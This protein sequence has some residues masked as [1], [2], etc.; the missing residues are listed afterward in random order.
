VDNGGDTV[1][2]GWISTTTGGEH[3]H[4]GD[5]AAAT[6]ASMPNLTAR[7]PQQWTV[8]VGD[9]LLS[10]KFQNP[11]SLLSLTRSMERGMVTNLGN[12]L[13][14]WKRMLDLLHVA[15]PFHTETARA[16]GWKAPP[17]ASG[18]QAVKIYKKANQMSDEASNPPVS[19][20]KQ[21]LSP[22]SLSSE[23][24]IP[25]SACAVLLTV[26]PWCPRALLD[27]MV[28]VWLNDFGFSRVGFCCGTGAAANAL[29]THPPPKEKS[30]DNFFL[31][32]SCVVDLGWSATHVVPSLPYPTSRS[33]VQ[34]TIVRSAVRRVPLGGR[35]L[36]N[37][38]RYQ[39]SYRQWNLMDQEFV[40]RDV[41]EKACEVS[42]RF[43]EWMKLAS[44]VPA[45][46]RPY[47]REYLLPDFIRTFRGEMRLPQALAAA[48]EMESE[49]GRG[50]RNKD[51]EDED[52]EDS[53]ID[54]AEMNQ[55]ENGAD[56]NAKLMSDGDDDSGDD[57][58][59]SPEQIRRRLLQQREEENRRRR[60]EEAE[61]QVL[62]LSLERFA[63]PEVLFRPSDAGLPAEWA[64]LPA[65]IVQSICACPRPFQPALYRSIY[66]TG[67][68]SRMPGLRE[69][70]EREL[71]ALAPCE[72]N[73]SV[74][75]CPDPTS[76]AWRGACL[77]ARQRPV[78]TW[79]VSREDITDASFSS[80][81][82]GKHG[83]WKRMGED[84]GSLLV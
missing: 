16:F 67:G 13:Q 61:Q 66:L 50:E 25:A 8:L 49:Q 42:P 20:R 48:R 77:H 41:L 71:R 4:G 62:N 37:L 55:N 18:L 60:E 11:N 65:A 14:V 12:Q 34:Q 69:R 74:T 30:S 82:S 10:K 70:L 6:P 7:L 26:H 5:E 2:Y 29:A 3:D 43:D 80:K 38:W 35:H 59:E 58:N 46:R 15:I 79:S 40:L 17:P 28:S 81:S 19:G 33:E 21:D 32:T 27:A 52:E 73:V 9:Q 22:A 44:R 76:Q 51:E 45:G 54:E 31:R 78:E 84:E 36:V 64:S 24:W 75:A 53:D 1:K 56:G 83:V 68:L 39:T 47:D 57:D 23:T 72:C 63:I